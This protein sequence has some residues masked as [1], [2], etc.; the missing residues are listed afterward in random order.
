MVKKSADSDTETCGATN[1]NGEPCQLPAGWG[2]PGSGGTRCRFHGGDSTGPEDTSHLDGNDHAA[3]NPGGGAPPLNTNAAVHHGF[4]DWR[5][6]YERL[7]PART[8]RVDRLTDDVLETAEEHAP[9]VAAD[10]REELAREM[11]VLSV[12]AKSALADVFA[13]AEDARGFV[14]E[15]SDGHPRVN[16]ALAADA[17]LVRRRRE[18]AEELR[19]W[20]GFQEAAAGR[21]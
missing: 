2:T 18:I 8:A 7:A 14:V 12:L 17:G 10:R 13:D 5:K 20:P 3:G 11:A 19:L 16:P 1:R 21:W 4:A 15:A 9:E 6:T